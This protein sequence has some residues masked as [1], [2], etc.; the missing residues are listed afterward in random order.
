MSKFA[1]RWGEFVSKWGETPLP[2]VPQLT[3]N[4]LRIQPTAAAFAAYCQSRIKTLEN[5]HCTNYDA[6]ELLLM[7]KNDIATQVECEVAHIANVEMSNELARRV[8][9]NVMNHD[10]AV[11]FAKLQSRS[12]L[13]ALLS[14]HLHIKKEEE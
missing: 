14:P 7:K 8:E 4:R 10:E 5:S 3:A 1:E 11:T 9:D 12:C 6:P 2:N 13:N